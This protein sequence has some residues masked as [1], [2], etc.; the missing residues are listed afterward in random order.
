LTLIAYGGTAL[1]G[2]FAGFL[3]DTMYMF[4]QNE[5]ILDYNDTAAG[6]NFAGQAA[7]SANFITFRVNAVPEPSALGLVLVTCAALSLRRRRSA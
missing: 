3:D 2:G 7:G 6:S 5:W 4:G 1:T